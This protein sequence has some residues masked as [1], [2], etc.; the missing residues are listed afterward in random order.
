[1]KRREKAEKAILAEHAAAEKGYVRAHVAKEAADKR[2]KDAQGETAAKKIL[3]EYEAASKAYDRA[4]TRVERA[5]NRWRAAQEA[6][7]EMERIGIQP[8]KK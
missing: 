4:H 3:A 8:A 5:T 6:K 7:A 1:M 2:L